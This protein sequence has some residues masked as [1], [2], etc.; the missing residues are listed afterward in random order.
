MSD[1]VKGDCKYGSKCY[2]TNPEHLE[3][4]NHPQ[5]K[6]S[7]S[8]SPPA[9]NLRSPRNDAAKRS[10]SPVSP[11]KSPKKTEII[12]NASKKVKKNSIKD[13]FSKS[14]ATSNS[15]ATKTK[16]SPNSSA[17]AGENK[18]KFDVPDVIQPDPSKP[19]IHEFFTSLQRRDYLAA[20]KEYKDMLMEPDKFIRQHFLVKMPDDF[21]HFWVW[22]SEQ[23]GDKGKPEEFFS[24]FNLELVGPFDVLSGKFNDLPQFE[25]SQ[26]LRHYRYFYD[27]PEFQV[28][29]AFV[30]SE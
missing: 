28:S 12:E 8:E 4:Y 15:T 7:S 20:K 26:Y 9:Y 19:T 5:T 2:R 11:H 22:V 23:A 3:N 13:Y 24:D 6:A 29:E 1:T 25:P 16:T 27:P 21:Y 30:L 17:L 10:V 18:P 14:P